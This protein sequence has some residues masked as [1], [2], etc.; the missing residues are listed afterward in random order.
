MVA[1]AAVLAGAVVAAGVVVSDFTDSVS[2]LAAS[3]ADFAVSS[4][5]GA[6]TFGAVVETGAVN[7][8]TGLLTTGA[9]VCA[10]AVTA[11]SKQNVITVNEVTLGTG[12]LEPSMFTSP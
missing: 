1:G 2:V 10:P 9:G 5:A 6:P 8:A 7:S 11:V 12:D 4:L 3:L